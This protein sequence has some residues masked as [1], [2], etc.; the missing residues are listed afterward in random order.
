MEGYAPCFANKLTCNVSGGE[1]VVDRQPDLHNF[2]VF[3]GMCS[4]WPCA[5][6]GVELV[7]NSHNYPPN[8]ALIPPPILISPQSSHIPQS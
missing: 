3:P 5:I 2:V 7:V 8:H 1:Q 4:S 6:A